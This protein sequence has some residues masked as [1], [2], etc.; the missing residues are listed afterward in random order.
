[1]EN[2]VDILATVEQ[3]QGE[4]MEIKVLP[5]FDNKKIMDL[6]FPA[7]AI[8][9]VILRKNNVIIPKGDT[10]INTDDILIIFTT[11]DNAAEIKEF[12]KVK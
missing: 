1:M 8:I 6:K 10:A 12:F 2:D 9:G 7:R 11:A 4:V 3:G 5:E